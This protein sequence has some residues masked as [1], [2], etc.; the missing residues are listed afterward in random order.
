MPFQDFC[1]SPLTDSV[2]L[3]PLEFG[4][5]KSYYFK[6]K[7]YKRKLENF[8]TF[9]CDRLVFRRAFFEVR[10]RSSYRPRHDKDDSLKVS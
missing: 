6:K 5:E 3:L 8:P 4:L 7:N 10:R 2:H 9:H 1:I